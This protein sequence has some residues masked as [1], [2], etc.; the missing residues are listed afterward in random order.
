[1][2]RIVRGE[3]FMSTMAGVLAAGVV[4]ATGASA[5]ATYLITFGFVAIVIGI[6]LGPDR[7]RLWRAKRGGSPARRSA[8]E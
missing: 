7:V 2:K 8:T 3:A 5:G 4:A 6:R 1:M